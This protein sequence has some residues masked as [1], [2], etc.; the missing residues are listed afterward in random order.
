MMSKYSEQYEK[1]T[2]IILTD[3]Y[4]DAIQKY[5]DWLESKLEA[6]EVAI[7]KVID[8]AKDC[9][10]EDEIGEDVIAILTILDKKGGMR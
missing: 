8:R 3:D 5:C 1:E 9:E 2:G 4:E 7:Q 6:Y 10:H